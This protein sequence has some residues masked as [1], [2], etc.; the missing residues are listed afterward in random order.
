MDVKHRVN[1]G[2]SKSQAE[3]EAPG[4]ETGLKVPVTVPVTVLRGLTSSAPLEQN[5]PLPLTVLLP[6]GISTPSVEAPILGECSLL[7]LHSLESSV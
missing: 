2:S 6:G 1:P 3:R 5:L 7:S 4:C